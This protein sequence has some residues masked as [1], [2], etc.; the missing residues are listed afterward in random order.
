ML[1]S[2]SIPQMETETTVTIKL[3]SREEC[4]KVIQNFA[5]DL[6]VLIRAVSKLFS[7]GVH[8]FFI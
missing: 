7:V 8:K 4:E 1:T 2:Q 3:I 5:Q 6:S